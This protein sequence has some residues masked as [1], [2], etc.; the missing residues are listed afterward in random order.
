MGLQPGKI[1]C[2]A[3]SG[4]SSPKSGTALAS[5]PGKGVFFAF[6][7]PALMNRIS[8][9]LSLTWLALMVGAVLLLSATNTRRIAEIERVSGLVNAAAPDDASPTGYARGARN[10][11][12]PEK[13]PP[14]QPW[15]MDVQQMSVP[16][17]GPVT[18]AAYDNAPEGRA[19]HGPSPYRAWLR[20]IAGLERRAGGHPAGRAVERAALHANPALHALLCLGVGLLAAWRFGPATGGLVALGVA[21]LFPLNVA[22]APGPDDHALLLGANLTA[23][24]LLVAGSHGGGA[25]AK[26]VC[27]AL[28]GGAAGFGLWLDAGT[29]LTALGAVGCGGL[30]IAWFSARPAAGT[31]ASASLPWRWWAAGGVLIAT[32]GWLV[33]GRPGGVTGL[34]LDVNHPVLGFTWL[35]GAEVLVRLHAWR[36]GATRPRDR[37][38]LAGAVV[39]LIAGPA[40]LLGHGGRPALFGP[41]GAGLAAYTAAESFA[42][43]IGTDGVSLPLAAAALPLLLGGLGLWQLRGAMAPRPGLLL[44]L[45]TIGILLPVA[46]VQLRWWGLLDTALLGLLA[47]VTAGLPAGFALIGWRTALV[48]LLVPGLVLTWPRQQT[49]EELSPMQARALIER[50][51]AQWLAA[52][53]E[54]GAIAF[55]P[56]AL[57]GSLCYYGGLRVIASPYPGNQDGL[58]LAVRIAATT[59]TDEAQA[60]LTRR[61]IQYVIVPSWDSVLDE[62]ARIGSDTP[63]RSLIALL[64]QWLPPRWLR[65]VPYQMPLISGL[66]G[67]SVAIFEVVE[68]QENAIALSRLAEY[69]METGRLDLA[70]AVSDSLEQ[71][72]ASDAGAMI[73]RAQVALARGESRSLAR[74]IPELLPAI[75]DGRDED[76]PWERRANL[77]IVLAQVKRPDLA[78]AQV[79]FCLEEADAERLRSLGTVSLYRLLTLARGFNLGF[80][81]PALHDTALALL[82]EEFR[83]QVPR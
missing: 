29:Q 38:I 25:G 50:D 82:P 36:Q 9:P 23:M 14:G 24:L 2:A 43:W 66:G 40:W 55:A 17:A 20:L 80:A 61:G 53:S 34:T 74:V 67:E 26:R 6:P 54:P 15:I 62:F 76:L 35:A 68:P 69:F 16:G 41:D 79:A 56:P 30:L 42:G 44:A 81:D 59:S 60:L 78:R 51:L 3:P 37:V 46:L 57:S 1:D 47:V 39:I 65:P 71:A 27:F 19:I 8:R 70:V 58:A 72:F 32:A 33:E 7:R 18:Q 21:V 64:R 28:A 49:A 52:R 22:F 48:A 31:P 12:L 45:G 73:A 75:A 63:E 4:S 11:I 77:A 13:T 5:F 10:L 83:N